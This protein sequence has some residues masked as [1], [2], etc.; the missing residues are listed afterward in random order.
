MLCPFLWIAIFF[1]LLLPGCASSDKEKGRVPFSFYPPVQEEKAEKQVIPYTVHFNAPGVESLLPEVRDNSQLVWLKMT[2][3]DSRVA[4][5]RRTLDDVGTARKVLQSNGY[6]SGNVSYDIQWDMKPVLVQITLTPGPLYRI[7]ETSVRYQ[8]ERLIRK[9]KE[10]STVPSFLGKQEGGTDFMRNPP[11]TLASFG[12]QKGDPAKAQPILN[13]E[14]TLLTA[15]HNEGYP[16]AALGKSRYTIDRA[17]KTLDAEAVVKTGPLLRMGEV[18]VKQELATPEGEEAS[19]SVSDT[20]LNRL[21]TWNT[22]QFW[23]ER[24]IKTYRSALQETGLFSSIRLEPDTKVIDADGNTPVDLTV[25]DAPPRTISGG[26]QYSTDTGAGVRGAWE[27][28]NLWGGGEQL[29][30]TLPISEDLQFLS[31]SFRKPAFGRRNQALVGEAEARHE[32]SDAYDQTAAYLA[33][34]I[35]RRFSGDWKHWWGSIRGSV[36]GGELN[37]NNGKQAYFLFGVPISLRRDT[38]NNLFD[39]TEGT[40]LAFTITPYTGSYH[41][42][43]TTV[44]TRVDGS[45]YIT[46]FE[47]S[48]IVLAARAAAGSLTAGGVNDIPASLRFYAGGGGSVRGYKYQSLGPHDKDGDPI[49]GLSFTEVGA[50]VRFRITEHFGIVPFVDGGMV[51]DHMTPKWGK[52]M[53][54]GAGLGFRYYTVIGPVRLDVATPLEDRKHNKRI[55]VYLSIGQAF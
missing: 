21:A 46:P 18:R 50:E 12:V 26:V 35:E 49:G 3:P 16:K 11:Q 1:F 31:A 9:E 28:R 51:Y 29:R 33:G 27:N 30:L 14:A 19:P 34:G 6:Y 17:L 15:L 54:W 13:A 47:T 24:L 23:D 52:D 41:G 48:R 42:A 36:E 25:R 2:P 55:Q 44:R 20:Y 7:G 40:R 45:A 4:L 43:L 8:T 32:T 39:P 5:E 38:T 37:D 53:A 22:G 10:E